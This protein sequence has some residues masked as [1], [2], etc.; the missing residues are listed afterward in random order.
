LDPLITNAA[1]Y[2]QHI[3]ISSI[4]AGSSGR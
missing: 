3:S 1:D 2:T 4:G